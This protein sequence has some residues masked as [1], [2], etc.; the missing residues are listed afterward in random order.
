M[1]SKKPFGNAAKRGI[2]TPG[3]ETITLRSG[4]EPCNILRRSPGGGLGMKVVDRP[5]RP[6]RSLPSGRAGRPAMEVLESDL[7]LPEV[8]LGGVIGCGS[9]LFPLDG[10]QVP[11][12]RVD[13]LEQFPDLCRFDRLPRS[14]VLM[15]LF[16]ALLDLLDERLSQGIEEVDEGAVLRVIDVAQLL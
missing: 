1:A 4:G 3:E 6:F 10:L 7:E 9:D 2:P 15:D 12:R 16:V 5:I 14:V 11:F 8:L 13:Q